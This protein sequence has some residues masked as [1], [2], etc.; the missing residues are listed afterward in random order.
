MLEYL[1]ERESAARL[2]HAIETCIAAGRVTP[3]LGGTWT[4]SEVT[5]AVKSEI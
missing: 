3:D 4:T 5:E 2:R 1:G